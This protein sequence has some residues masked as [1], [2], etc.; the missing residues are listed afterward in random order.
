MFWNVF[1][2]KI[3]LK[4]SL[5]SSDPVQIQR[6]GPAQ[7]QWERQNG[8]KASFLLYNANRMAQYSD[9]DLIDVLSN[10]LFVSICLEPQMVRVYHIK[11]FLIIVCSVIGKKEC[12]FEDVMWVGITDTRWNLNFIFNFIFLWKLT[13]LPMQ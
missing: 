3:E 6:D 13:F 5:K 10:S 1:N 4:Q 7:V 9:L 2:Q 11:T 8:F 12:H